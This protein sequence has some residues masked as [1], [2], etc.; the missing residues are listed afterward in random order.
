MDFL[1]TSLANGEVSW[2]ITDTKSFEW[3]EISMNRGAF[4]RRMDS[5]KFKEAYV[6]VYYPQTKQIS[7]SS[8]MLVSH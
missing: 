1:K 2:L 7:Y 8:F 6:G 3:P 4:L 5:M